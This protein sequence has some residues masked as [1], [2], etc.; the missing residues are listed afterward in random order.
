MG[1]CKNTG[2]S[3]D[4]DTRQEVIPDRY[5]CAYFNRFKVDRELVESLINTMKDDDIYDMLS[6]Y[7]NQP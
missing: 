4:K 2:Y 5:P 3:Y 1:L 6:V 7:G